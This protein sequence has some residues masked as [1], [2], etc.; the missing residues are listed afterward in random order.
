[1]FAPPTL[2]TFVPKAGCGGLSGQT[3]EPLKVR[4]R[5][6]AEVVDEAGRCRCGATAFG[7]APHG[8]V[9]NVRQKVMSAIHSWSGP[10]R[11]T[12]ARS[13]RTALLPRS[14]TTGSSRSTEAT[15]SAS[16]GSAVP[17]GHRLTGAAID[18]A[19]ASLRSVPD[20]PRLRDS[21][22][23]AEF[24]KPGP[25]QPGSARNQWWV[26]SRGRPLGCVTD[27]GDASTI[28][29]RGHRSTAPTAGRP[30]LRGDAPS[31]SDSAEPHDPPERRSPARSARRR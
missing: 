22:A 27:P 24:G 17:D 6:A 7:P 25:P 20:D 28:S 2:T 9:A 19:A 18:A 13:C 12:G 23:I 31:R 15:G 1:V 10:C 29:G 21:N 26:R 8:P 16:A 4:V 14:S 3:V 30:E 5:R 11:R